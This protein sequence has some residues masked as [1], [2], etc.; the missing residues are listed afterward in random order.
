[1]W[2][3]GL[4]TKNV[5]QYV[6]LVGLGTLNAS[7]MHPRETYRL[8]IMRGVSSVILCHNHPSGN[9]EPSEDDIIVTKRLRDAGDIVG[10]N[11]LDHVIVGFVPGELP[12]GFYSMKENGYV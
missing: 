2:A 9:A 8:A 1:M 11:L 4:N 12:P 5:V 6:E 7:L 10:I 3:I